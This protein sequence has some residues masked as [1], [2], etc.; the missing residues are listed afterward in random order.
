MTGLAPANPARA[1]KIRHG[2]KRTETDLAR[3]SFLAELKGVR[4][5]RPGINITRIRMGIRRLQ[6]P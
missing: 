6:E 4:P 1:G 5:S 2:K 3:E